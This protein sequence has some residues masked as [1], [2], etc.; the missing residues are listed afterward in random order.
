MK[1]KKTKYHKIFW[2]R[3]YLDIN[4]IFEEKDL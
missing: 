3:F 4:L 1:N 2:M